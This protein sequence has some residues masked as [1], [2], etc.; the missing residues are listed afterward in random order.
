M[1]FHHVLGRIFIEMIVQSF[2]PVRRFLAFQQRY[3]GN[4]LDIFRHFHSGKFK[5]GRCVVNVLH[6]FIDIPFSPEVFRQT[7]N[8]RGTH[9]LFV[10]EALVEPTVLAHIEALIRSINHER[11]IIQSFFFQIIQH[12]PHIVVQRLH[13]FHI[14]A[15][16]TLE[17]P[18]G[19][20]LA[21]RILLIKIINDRPVEF[22]PCGTLSFIHAT[23]VFLIK[24]FQPGFFVRAQHLEVVNHIHI[25]RNA[26]LLCRSG[27]TPFIII[28][29]VIRQGESLVF[30]QSQITGICQPV[31]VNGFVV[32]QDTERL[33]LIPL[34][35]HPVDGVICN[36]VRH[37]AMFL[38]RIIILGDEVRVIVIALSGHNLP[39]VETGRQ[40]FE[41]PFAD[42]G[43]FITG[44]LQ[45]FR[46]CLL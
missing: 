26:H 20:F 18:V 37:I 10:H 4:A 28:K 8:Q 19:E 33:I 35:L 6:H 34:V 13:G 41:M 5:E 36:E 11:I 7:H 30:I 22:V 43:C 9:G 40:T 27:G 44:L 38:Y 46:E 29:E 32:D 1:T 16:V 25:F 12:T 17:L 31:T 24:R 42:E 15:Y 23:D 2:P 21:L 39:I 45:E 14:V 3:Q